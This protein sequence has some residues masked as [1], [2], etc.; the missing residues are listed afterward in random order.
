MNAGSRSG[1]H[2]LRPGKG[3]A[4]TENDKILAKISEKMLKYKKIETKNQK[5]IK[6]PRNSVLQTKM[7]KFFVPLV[8]FLRQDQGFAPN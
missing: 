1:I 6:K 5:I 2:L 8:D 7:A 4:Q 3:W